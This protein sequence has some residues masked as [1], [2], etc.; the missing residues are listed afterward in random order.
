M[1]DLKFAFRQLLKNPGFTAVAVLTLAL[2]IGAT[3][4]IF[5]VTRTLLFD[6][7]PVANAERFIELVAVHKQQGWSTPGLDSVTAQAAVE[8]TNLFARIGIY[9]YDDLQLRGQEFP[10]TVTGLKV[11]PQFLSL[12]TARP[13]LGRTFGAREA[14]PGQENLIIISHRLWQSRFGGDSAIIGKPIH[15]TTGTFTVVGVMPPFFRF[16]T[17]RD[18]YWR[19]FAGPPPPTRGADGSILYGARNIGV[20]AEI[21]PGVRYSDVQSY[22]D[23]L[24]QRLAAEHPSTKEFVARVRALREIFVKPEVSRT[25]WTLVATAALTLLIVCANVANLQLASIEARRHELAIRAAIG[26]GRFRLIRQLLTENV[27]LACL[28]GLAGLMVTAFGLALLTKLIPPE[29]PSFKPISLDVGVLIVASTVSVATG[30]LFGLAPAWTACRASVGETLKLGAGKATSPAGQ[31]QFSRGLI[32]GQVALALMLLTGAGLMARSVV[33]LLNV[34]PGFD[35]HNVV[36]IYPGIDLNRY[37]GDRTRS[38]EYL[39]AVLGDL[40]QRVGSLPGVA[41]AGIC[42]SDYKEWEVF[43]NEGGP[44]VKLQSFFVGT[45]A[46]NPLAVLRVP[47]RQGRW[48]ERNDASPI[49]P[50]VLINE[51]AAQRLWPGENPLG[52]RLWARAIERQD[53]LDSFEVVGVVG[54]TR[55]SRYDEPLGPTVFR[56]PTPRDAGNGRFLVVRT[57]ERPVTL[58]AAISREIKA[59]GA[60]TLSPEFYNLEERLYNATAGHRTLML[61]L[62]SFAGV[63]LLLS[64]IGL[65]A[66]LAYAV[67]RR[68]KE[69]GIRMALGAARAEVM[70]LIVGQGMRL[71]GAG[72]LLGLAGAWPGSRLLGSFL[73]GVRTTDPLTYFC[74]ALLLTAVALVACWLPA[75]RAAKVHPMEALRCE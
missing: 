72:V 9:Q 63:G 45:D 26:A 50:R 64:A 75:R 58:Y 47:L 61:Y 39:N 32:V 36:E 24:S 20:V 4:A 7:L 12:W 31:T 73:F 8:Q 52:K 19:P 34:N 66:M 38:D 41:A 5:S 44:P 18:D 25:L 14:L 69:I 65:Y 16:P 71:T 10:E 23:L 51:S 2:G 48:L 55:W 70:K 67:A 30:I 74:V 1:N 62:A 22:L 13:I 33:A 35:P 43:A 6:P 54:N 59:A 49:A 37:R 15:F 68:T 56:V 53:A 40:Q 42:I 21:K 27:L 3:T 60:D 11:T 17:G 46:A 57:T 28:A 29:L